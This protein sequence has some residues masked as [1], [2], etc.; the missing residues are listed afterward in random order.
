[1]PRILVVGSSEEYGVV[2][3]DELPVKETN[4]LRPVSPYA[5]SKVAQ[6]LMG[7]Q[8]FQNYGMPIVRTRAFNQDG[9]RRPDVFVTGNFARQ[10]VEIE[11]GHRAPVIEVGNLQ[12]RRDYTDV[13]DIVRGYW[14]LLEAGVAG[15]VYNLCSGKAWAIQGIL[16]CLLAQ[17]RVQGIAVKEDPARLRPSDVPLVV[18]DGTKIAEAVGWR[19]VIPFER[20]LVDILEYWRHRLSRS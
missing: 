13:R 4:P 2:R 18:G 9:P 6:D 11:L 17:S 3:D 20:T 7:F 14:Q 8:Y 12:V 5:V 16:D 10:I 19:P 1:M 15:D